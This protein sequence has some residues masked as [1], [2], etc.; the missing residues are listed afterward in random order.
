MKVHVFIDGDNLFFLQKD[1]L[2]WRIDFQKFIEFCKQY[3]DIEAATYYLGTTGD[4]FDK[5][6]FY[7]RLASFGYKVVSRPIKE[8]RTP[9]GDTVYKSNLDMIM[10]RDMC[11]AISHYDS[12]V[13]VTGDGDFDCILE[14]LAAAGKKFKIISTKRFASSIMKQMAGMDF[15]DLHEYRKELELDV[16][17]GWMVDEVNDKGSE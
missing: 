4:A 5:K 16:D 8:I 3:G 2:G 1:D 9:N 10:V 14:T 11:L 15:V 6:A 12:V 17:C 7:S 13:L